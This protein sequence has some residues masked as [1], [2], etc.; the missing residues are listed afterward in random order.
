MHGFMLFHFDEICLLQSIHTISKRSAMSEFHAISYPSDA[1]PVLDLF[2]CEQIANQQ[3][4][5]QHTLSIIQQL[6]AMRQNALKM[7]M[8]VYLLREEFSLS[9]EG[10][11][12]EFC[13]RNFEP[14][15]L[16]YD[17]IRMAV[18]TGKAI[19]NLEKHGYQNISELSN[20][21]RAALFVFADAPVEV[22]AQVLDEIVDVV[23]ERGGRGHT[24]DEIKKRI[25]EMSEEIEVK[26]GLLKEKDAALHRLNTTIRA[27]EEEAAG[28]REEIDKL[29]RKLSQ[30]QVSQVQPVVT[31][32]PQGIKDVQQLQTKIEDSISVKKDELVKIDFEISKLKEEH[33]RLQQVALLRSQAQ[34][35]LDGLEADIRSISTKY[36]YALVEKIRSAD[37]NNSETLYRI[38]TV[39][40]ALADQIAPSLI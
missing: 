38:S 5:I 15:G 10:T 20:L 29:H 31:Q 27:R 14:Q 23:K 32:F 30:Q 13:L 16:T 1:T 11:W 24:A 33:Q 37:V 4:I 34:S 25:D 8:H 39:L 19:L 6:D 36:T 26:N 18:R 17:S 3:A 2:G 28:A 40:R 22:Q 7:S 35:A 21:S 9:G 12:K